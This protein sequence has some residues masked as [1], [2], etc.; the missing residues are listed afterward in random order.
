[1]NKLSIILNS[2]FAFLIIVGD[3]LYMTIGGLLIKSITSALFLLLGLI[4]LVLALKSQ[5]YNLKFGILLVIGLF[6]A[7]LG[8]IILE[9]N[10]IIGALLFATGHIFFFISYCTIIKFKATDLIA[11]AIIFT[12]FTLFI[13]LAPIF[14][15]GGILMQGVCIFYTVIISCMLGK[16]ITNYIKEKSKLNL[17]LL[18][19]SVLFTFSDFMLLL[20]VFANLPRIVGIL[21]LVSYY[22]AEIFLALSPAFARS[23]NK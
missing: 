11:G 3:I 22:P 13:L 9:I 14:D 19:G 1:M 7:M 18:I 20:N 16:S 6:F 10:F 8:D 12:P 2:I 23:E 15:F 17:I 21:C 4:N 5:K